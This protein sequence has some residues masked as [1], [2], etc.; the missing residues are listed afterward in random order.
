MLEIDLFVQAMV[1]AFQPFDITR[2][3]E[4]GRRQIRK[5]FELQKVRLIEGLRIRIVGVDDA[6][7]R[8]RGTHRRAHRGIFVVSEHR[9]TI[10]ENLMRH[11][12][13][14]LK[15]FGPVHDRGKVFAIPIDEQNGHALGG[16]YLDQDVLEDADLTGKLALRAAGARH[17]CLAYA[18][19]ER[20]QERPPKPSLRPRRLSPSRGLPARSHAG[21]RPA[22]SRQ[23]AIRTKPSTFQTSDA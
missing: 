8:L 2:R 20:S 5:L 6:D 16:R 18:L 11:Q 22:N 4:S 12:A 21:Q 1:F 9:K 15:R 17:H 23:Y 19:A 7:L 14:H 3:L 13:A 10:R